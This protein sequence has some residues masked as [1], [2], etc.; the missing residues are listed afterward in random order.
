MPASVQVATRP[1][2]PEVD[3]VGVR[4]DDEDA[5]GL[6]KRFGG[7]A[8]EPTALRIDQPPWC[9]TSWAGRGSSVTF[10]SARTNAVTSSVPAPTIA[11]S[12][13][14]YASSSSTASSRPCR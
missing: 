1:G 4:N 12:A 2:V 13:P 14:A 3:V 10:R 6:G 9:Q 8:V 5:L 11:S 7:H